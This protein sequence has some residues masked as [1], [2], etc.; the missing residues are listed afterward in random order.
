MD[1][2]FASRKN[3]L[4]KHTND[5][6][7]GSESGSAPIDVNPGNP[8]VVEH[9]CPAEDYFKRLENGNCLMYSCT[10]QDVCDVNVTCAQE[11]TFVVKQADTFSLYTYGDLEK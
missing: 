3:L 5:A 6:G 2:A 9:S 11:K 4:V 1:R 7:S 10:V 8:F